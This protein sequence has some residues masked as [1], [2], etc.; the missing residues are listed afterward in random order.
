MYLDYNQVSVPL[1]RHIPNY[2]QT[3]KFLKSIDLYEYLNNNGD[4]ELAKQYATR[5]ETEKNESDNPL[6]NFTQ[7]NNLITRLKE[8]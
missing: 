4:C 2:E 5:L 1:K 6:F 7:I 8:K 3:T